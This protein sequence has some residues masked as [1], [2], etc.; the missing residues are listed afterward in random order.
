[1]SPARSARDAA[2]WLGPTNLRL[3]HVR[4][5]NDDLEWMQEVQG[6]TVWAVKHPPGFFA[7]LPAL[8]VLDVQGGSGESASF[9]EGCQ[10]LFHLNLNQI[11]GL[12]DL[13]AV[14]DLVGLRFLSVYG[15]PRV[16]SLPD[17][18]ALVH[19]E[20][21]ELGSLKGLRDGIGPALRTP[22]LQELMLLRAVAVAEG[23]AALIRDH[24]TLRTFDWFAEDVPRRVVDPFIAQAEK[25]ARRF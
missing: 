4:V 24:P 16:E 11:R 7:R 17:L 25:P 8:Q 12:T 2:Q 22:T 21:L 3:D 5:T 10:S 14:E 18:S 20:R 1:M 15:Q 13:A 23:D 19:L 6:L 9:V